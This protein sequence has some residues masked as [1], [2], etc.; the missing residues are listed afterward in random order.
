MPSEHLQNGLWQQ[1]FELGHQ[2]QHLVSG[3]EDSGISGFQAP[4]AANNDISGEQGS[5]RNSGCFGIGAC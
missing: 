4:L 5:K 2:N 3:A 1:S